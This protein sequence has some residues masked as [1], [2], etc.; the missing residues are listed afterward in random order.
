V[1]LADRRRLRQVLL[2][3]LSNAVKYNRPGGRVAL[4]C[5]EGG[6]GGVRVHV[7]DTG[8]GIRPEHLD[9]VFTPF[10]RLDAAQAS[11]D[12]VGLGLALS[13]RLAEAMGGSI[14]VQSAHGEGSTF[15][16]ELVRADA[17]GRSGSGSGAGVAEA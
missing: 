10:E 7:A 5:D 4:S 13:R 12:G 16:L 17:S 6:A 2:N 15:T 11:V 3:L 8:R 1:V 9:L 14:T